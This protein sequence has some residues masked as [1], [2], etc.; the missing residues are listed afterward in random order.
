MNKDMMYWFNELKADYTSELQEVY[1]SEGYDVISDKV[2]DNTEKLINVLLEY[3]KDKNAYLSFYS[4]S[5]DLHITDPVDTLIN[6]DEEDIV[7][8]IHDAGTTMS[9]DPYIIL[10][11]LE[12]HK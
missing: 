4:A 12:A 11:F 7:V 9:D 8:S 1:E 2:F 3:L 5:I 10:E 6:I